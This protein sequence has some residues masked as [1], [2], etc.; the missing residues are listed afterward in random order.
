[1][2][3]PVCVFHPCYPGILSD[4]FFRTDE[5][6]KNL[7]NR[8]SWKHTGFL[9]ITK[10]IYP[11]AKEQ[12]SVPR[13]CTLGNSATWTSQIQRKMTSDCINIGHTAFCC[14]SFRCSLHSYLAL[15]CWKLLHLCFFYFCYARGNGKKLHYEITYLMRQVIQR[16]KKV[17]CC[18][19]ISWREKMLEK[20]L[21]QFPQVLCISAKHIFKATAH[22]QISPVFWSLV[23]N[24]PFSSVRA[25]PRCCGTTQH[26]NRVSLLLATKLM[27]DNTLFLIQ[28]NSTTGL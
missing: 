21:P 8:E 14:H 16:S 12:S 15:S 10:N 9:R 28:M 2:R 5:I 26:R 1:M 22:E 18:S 3:L 7:L 19:D 25:A 24:P 17:L 6:K 13:S 11:P 4:A 27:N 20:T 23:R